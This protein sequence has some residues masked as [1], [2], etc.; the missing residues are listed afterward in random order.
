MGNLLVR[1]PLQERSRRTEDRVLNAT[2]RLLE[3]KWFSDIS[4]GEIAEAA[5]CGVGT[6]YGRFA[7]KEALLQVLKQKFLQA[8]EQTH[9]ELFKTL[10]LTHANLEV[11]VNRLIAVMVDS[12]RQHRGIVRELV[13]GTHGH[14]ASE[15]RHVNTAMTSL[16][17]RDIDLLLAALPARKRKS[18]RKQV[19]VAVL[20][21][22][23]L[24]Q[25]R[26]VFQETS[27]LEFKV[28]DRD[29]KRE[30][31]KM[32]LAYLIGISVNTG[33]RSGK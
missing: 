21:A 6:V 32:V 18:S 29:L 25:N 12:Y 22:I 24:I 7:S 10:E 8:T 23:N 19:A 26:V 27:P 15:D 20:A 9:D 3:N 1:R 33:R 14:S 4:L 31:P 16:L 28:S 13:I 17:E 11:R 2:R 30:V 5:G